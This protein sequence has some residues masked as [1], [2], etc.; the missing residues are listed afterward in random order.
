MKEVVVNQDLVSYCGL[1]CGACKK[2]INGK[3]PGCHE[4]NKAGWCAV[5]SCN[6]G[7]NYMSCADCK[8]FI[9]PV[10]CRKFNNFFSKFFALVFRS[11]RAAGVAKIKADGYRAFAAYMAAHNL[12][13]I[14]RK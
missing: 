11:D 3:C 13:A 9:N 7:H 12:Q 14:R 5:R 1:Y 8:E 4:N 6:I 2:F 10:D